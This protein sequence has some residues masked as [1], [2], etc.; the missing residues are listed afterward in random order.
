MIDQ[1]YTKTELQNKNCKIQN[2]PKL[3]LQKNY[4]IKMIDF[5]KHCELANIGLKLDKG[6]QKANFCLSKTMRAFW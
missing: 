3:Q 6:I 4:S 5:T 2:I 1:L